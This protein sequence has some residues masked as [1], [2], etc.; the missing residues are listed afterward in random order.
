VTI[1]TEKQA[2][3]ACRKVADPRNEPTSYEHRRAVLEGIIDLRMNYYDGDLE[4]TGAIPVPAPNASAGGGKK[5]RDSGF[6]ADSQGERRHGERSEGL[7]SGEGTQAVAEVLAEL[8][9]PPPAQLGARVFRREGQV[10]EL[11]RAGELF[12]KREL[13]L[14]VTVDGAAPRRRKIPQL[15]PE[16]HD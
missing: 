6:G 2:E 16:A 13:F 11:P 10:P 5:N 7:F 8:L 14:H 12:E 1:P 3:A 4:I 15:A 9:H